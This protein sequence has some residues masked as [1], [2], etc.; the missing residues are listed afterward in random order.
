MEERGGGVAEGEES[1]GGRGRVRVGRPVTEPRGALSI[2]HSVPSVTQGKRHGPLELA[3]EH[4]AY[5]GCIQR[6]N[7]TAKMSAVPG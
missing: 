7:N 1:R 5:V 3:T 4:T 6:S 2:S